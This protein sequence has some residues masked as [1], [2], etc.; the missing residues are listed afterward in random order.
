[1]SQL[2]VHQIPVLTDN[3]VY[4]ARCRVSGAT[5]VIDP[6]VAAPVLAEADRLGWR[7]T[8]ILNTHHH[9]D[10]VGGNLEIQ[11]ATG[12]TI[13]GPK[14]DRDRIPGID[15]EVDEGDSTRLGEAQAEVFFVPGHTRGHIAYWFAESDALFCG[16]TLFALGCGRLFEGTPQQMWN[17]LSKLK[18]LP[19]TARVYCAHEYTQANARFALTVDGANADLKARAQ[20]IDR[21]RAVGRPTV[22]STLADEL[23]TNP[24]LR[25]DAPDLAAQIGLAGADPVSVFA[26]VRARKDS[27]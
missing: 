15:V 12:C 9:G 1:M 13:V 2:D 4:L 23:A 6:A 27:F 22:P 10:H 11:R 20:D 3:Y 18:A 21:L 7:I 5:A 8:H 25:A 16:D 19:P 24:F 17:S 14:A 26:E